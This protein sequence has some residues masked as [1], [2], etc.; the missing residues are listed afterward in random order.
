MFSHDDL[1]GLEK[2]WVSD[3]LKLGHAALL[4]VLPDLRDVDCVARERDGDIV[5]AGE[6]PAAPGVQDLGRLRS[7]VDGDAADTGSS[8]HGQKC[9]A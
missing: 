5:G 9:S 1:I 3:H 7:S 8:A 2:V 4:V 6:V